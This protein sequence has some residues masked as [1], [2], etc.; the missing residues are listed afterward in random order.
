MRSE[1]FS[2][3]SNQAPVVRPL[4]SLTRE[5]SSPSGRRP[6]KSAK[7]IFNPSE[8]ELELRKKK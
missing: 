2:Q 6:P 7:T 8:V 4:R 5:R 1:T 3:P